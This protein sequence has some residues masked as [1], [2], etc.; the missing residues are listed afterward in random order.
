MKVEREINSWLLNNTKGE[1]KIADI[2]TSS[3]YKSFSI[4]A[5]NL[6]KLGF[7]SEPERIEL[8][9]VI[10]ETLDFMKN[11][12]EKRVA[13]VGS[14]LVEESKIVDIIKEENKN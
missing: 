9:S 10:G 3:V 5:D 8:S 2:L 13:K 4:I 1:Q 6:H 14:M 12:I 7:M 11:K